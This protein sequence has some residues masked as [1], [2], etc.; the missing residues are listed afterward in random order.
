MSSGLR[1]AG[2]KGHDRGQRVASHRQAIDRLDAS[3]QRQ[4]RVVRRPG[5]VEVAVI[6]DVHQRGP[7]RGN[8]PAGRVPA[9]AVEA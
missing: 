1:I 9:M 2:A 8:R 5:Q 3:P 4:R 7:G 6:A